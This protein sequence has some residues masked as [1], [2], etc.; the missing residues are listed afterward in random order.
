MESDGA[1]VLVAVAERVFLYDASNG[2]M[3]N[4]VKGH[5]DTVFCVAY[6]KDS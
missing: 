6:S 5:K 3:I 4:Y 2:E 1:Q